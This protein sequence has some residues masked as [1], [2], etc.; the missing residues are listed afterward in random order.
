MVLCLFRCIGVWRIVLHTIGFAGV[1]VLYRKQYSLL[2]RSVENV[3]D[4]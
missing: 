1:S 2:V 4:T 3:G